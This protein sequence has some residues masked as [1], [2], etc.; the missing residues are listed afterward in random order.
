MSVTSMAVFNKPVFKKT[1]YISRSSSHLTHD[2]V[3][4]T[5]K[6]V[7]RLKD[8]GY[9]LMLLMSPSDQQYFKE[10]DD[11][12]ICCMLANNSTWFSNELSPDDIKALY[13]PALCSQNS[14]INVYIPSDI[15]G[16]KLNNRPCDLATFVNIISDVS[17]SKKYTINIQVYHTGLYIYSTQTM[18]KWGAKSISIYSIDED[19]LDPD[20][21]DN[22][23]QFWGDLVKKSDQSLAQK[24]QELEATRLKLHALYDEILQEKKSNKDWEFKIGCLKKMI[25]NIIF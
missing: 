21:C 12:G 22:I 9:I 3:D 1:Y 4:I 23:E 19:M 24:V 16:L 14:T 7:Q 20:E 10:I 25:Q 6:R 2:L 11:A 8:K 18:H 5:I 15:G 13:H 17:Y